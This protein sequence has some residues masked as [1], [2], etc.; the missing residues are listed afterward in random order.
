MSGPY[1]VS[2]AVKRS[3]PR[4]DAPSECP[5][6]RRAFL[7]A[8]EVVDVTDDGRWHLAMRCANCRWI[9]VLEY[10]DADVDA[11][12]LQVQRDRELMEAAAGE[13]TIAAAETEV[14]VFALALRDDLILPEDF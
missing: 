10:G 2:V 5:C 12:D 9:G 14:A 13:L 6:C 8:D 11:L 7:V 1:D 4:T 3:T